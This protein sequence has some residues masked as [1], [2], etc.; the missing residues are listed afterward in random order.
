MFEL[1]LFVMITFQENIFAGH[2]LSTINHIYSESSI[3]D[4]HLISDKL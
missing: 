4:Q 2:F 1:N 3:S